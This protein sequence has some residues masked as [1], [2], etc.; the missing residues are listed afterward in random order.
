MVSIFHTISGS[1]ILQTWTLNRQDNKMEIVLQWHMISSENI[2][3]SLFQFHRY[4]L[5]IA[6]FIWIGDWWRA[7]LGITKGTLWSKGLVEASS[8]LLLSFPLSF[9]FYWLFKF[10]I[11]LNCIKI[12]LRFLLVHVVP[13]ISA[14]TGDGKL[15]LSHNKGEPFFFTFG[16]SEV[17]NLFLHIFFV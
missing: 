6:L 12:S 15:I 14:K 11:I 3:H 5:N 17:S 9:L 16:K 2:I 10:S 4:M 13:R 8:Y 1:Y 7:G